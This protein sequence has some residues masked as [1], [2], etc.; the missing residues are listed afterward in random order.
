MVLYRRS[1]MELIFD[2]SILKYSIGA[3][4]IILMVQYNA[5][6]IPK[7]TV[8]EASFSPGQELS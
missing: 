1:G 4:S 2:S 5:P 3:S 6:K 7:N 8:P